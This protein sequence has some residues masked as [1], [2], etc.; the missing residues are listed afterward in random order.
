MICYYLKKINHCYKTLGLKKSFTVKRM[1]KVNSQYYLN[2]F[3]MAESF[4]WCNKKFFIFWLLLFLERYLLFL[5]LFS[6]QKKLEI[7]SLFHHLMKPNFWQS[8]YLLLPFQNFLVDVYLD[9]FYYFEN[10]LNVLVQYFLK[11][12]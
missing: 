1:I 11:L 7:K 3:L 4:L 6:F 2:D 10:C 8:A 5:L 9:Q 12:I